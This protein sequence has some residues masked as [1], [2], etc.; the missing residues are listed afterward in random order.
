M[1]FVKKFHG[2]SSGERISKIGKNLPAASYSQKE[3]G[4]HFFG[5]LCIFMFYATLDYKKLLIRMRY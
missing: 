3:R 5:P 2:V 1:Y 4:A